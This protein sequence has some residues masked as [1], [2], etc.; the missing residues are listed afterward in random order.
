MRKLAWGLVIAALAMVF[1]LQNAD[2]V[3]IHFF[4]WKIESARLALVLLVTFISGIITG[5]VFLA[6]KLLKKTNSE[7]LDTALDNKRQTN[8]NRL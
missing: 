5:L 1:A 6:P 7:K 2:P 4:F 3:P 8:Q